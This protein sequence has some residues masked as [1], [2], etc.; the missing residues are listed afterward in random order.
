MNLPPYPPGEER[1]HNPVQLFIDQHRRIYNQGEVPRIELKNWDIMKPEEEDR[2]PWN[3]PSKRIVPPLPS[4]DP[5][6]FTVSTPS[7][8]NS[9]PQFKNAWNASQAATENMAAEI[10]S[11]WRDLVNWMLKTKVEKGHMSVELAE[12]IS[13]DIPSR[14]DYIAHLSAITSMNSTNTV[15]T[16]TPANHLT[17]TATRP[18]KTPR[19]RKK[20]GVTPRGPPLSCKSTKLAPN[21]VVNSNLH[22]PQ[23]LDVEVDLTFLE[24]LCEPFSRS[25]KVR[26]L[27]KVDKAEKHGSAPAPLKKPLT[28]LSLLG[29][30]DLSDGPAPLW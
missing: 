28:M 6:S 1:P 19:S 17:G 24:D 10:D 22:E 4:T 26:S 3:S 25:E 13:K 23:T 5:S 16:C 9:N 30:L 20:I 12:V 14:D 8:A 11:E 29:K 21:D 7:A 15:C 27:P 2:T 18:I